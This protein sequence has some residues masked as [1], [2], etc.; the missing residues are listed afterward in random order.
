MNSRRG[1]RSGKSPGS[2]ATSFTK[3]ALSNF[4]KDKNLKYTRFKELELFR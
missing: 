3:E 2:T 1:D 4:M